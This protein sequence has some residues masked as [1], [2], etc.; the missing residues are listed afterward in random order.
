MIKYIYNLF[1]AVKNTLLFYFGWICLHY[2]SVYLYQNYCTPLSFMG[3]LASPFLSLSPHC[4]ALRWVINESGIIIFTMW[5][6][7][8]IWVV[9]NILTCKEKSD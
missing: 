3:F 4:N 1:N 9:T 8:S 6:A 7:L 2:F 5:S